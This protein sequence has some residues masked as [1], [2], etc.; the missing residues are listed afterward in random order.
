[1]SSRNTWVAAAVTGALACVSASAAE[2][3]AKTIDF[4]IPAQSITTALRVYAE[5]TGEQV[6]FFSEVGRGKQS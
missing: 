3:A 4:D 5:K 1:M 2:P 6:V